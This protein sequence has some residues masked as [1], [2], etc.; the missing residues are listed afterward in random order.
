[1]YT[2]GIISGVKIHIE[3]DFAADAFRIMTNGNVQYKMTVT[4]AVLH[5]PVAVLNPAE[6]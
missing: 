6:W 1:M 4:K 3:L 2:G 5:T